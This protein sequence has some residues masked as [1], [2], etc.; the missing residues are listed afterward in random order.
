M[1]LH[2]S[3]R[4]RAAGRRFGATRARLAL[5][6]AR[7]RR[8]FTR[9]A[10]A[11]VILLGPG[12]GCV[13]ARAAALQPSL[14]DGAL[15]TSAI[16][17]AEREARLPPQ[18]LGA[19]GLV[20]SGRPDPRTGRPTPWPW[21]INVAG[22]G[23]FFDTKEAAVA[24]V[25][26]ARAAG[27]QSI[28]VGCMQ[29]NLMY[30]PDAFASLD[31]AFEPR[32][33]ASYAA[34]FLNRLMAQS[35][36]WGRAAA[37]YHSQTPALGDDYERRVIAT[38]PLASRYVIA[39]IG[40]AGIAPG[41]PPGVAPSLFALPTRPKAADDGLARYLHNY[42]PEFQRRLQQD[43]LGRAARAR[44]GVEP[45]AARPAVARSPLRAAGQN[46]RPRAWADR[47]QVTSSR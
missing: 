3:M 23:A 14:S 15:C 11:A 13:T 12:A 34:S 21:T 26:A 44:T 47:L 22:T 25:Q 17:A 46:G 1:Q 18:L 7:H 8:R 33:N 31:Q 6:S 10:V 16:L 42:T 9:L 32:A 4:G 30:H 45:L 43:A 27:V 20:E 37:G 35:G 28:D 36:D 5:L 39:G 24:A 2:R 19:I 41:A 29:I 40:T 38:W